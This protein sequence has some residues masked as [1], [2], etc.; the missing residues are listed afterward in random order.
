M[1]LEFPQSRV[2]DLWIY[3]LGHMQLLIRSLKEQNPWSDDRV[4]IQVSN[5]GRLCMPVQFSADAVVLDADPSSL[6]RQRLSGI[7]PEDQVLVFLLKGRV[8]GYL[9]TNHVWHKIDQG[10]KYDLAGTSLIDH[11]QNIDEGVLNLR[12]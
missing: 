1:F 11:M 3:T 6:L 2:F 8:V 4:L 7:A 10:S 9:R 5:A 12:K